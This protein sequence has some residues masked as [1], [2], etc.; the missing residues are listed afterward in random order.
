MDWIA[1]ARER[2]VLQPGINGSAE[3]TDITKVLA[4]KNFTPQFLSFLMRL[5]SEITSR[6]SSQNSAVRIYPAEACREAR[7]GRKIPGENPRKPEE[8]IGINLKLREV[9]EEPLRGSR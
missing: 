2:F 4:S 8:K 1:L 7:P 3:S 9:L 6:H 5:R